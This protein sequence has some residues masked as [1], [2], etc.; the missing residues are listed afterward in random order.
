MQAVLHMVIYQA[1]CMSNGCTQA[2]VGIALP[3]LSNKYWLMSIDSREVAKDANNA[4]L[5]KGNTKDILQ[6][7]SPQY[8]GLALIH[9]PGLQPASE[10]R[11]LP[12]ASLPVHGT[13]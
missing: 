10:A 8:C 6:E 7:L 12:S 9:W 3:M 2:H 13:G 4:S 1:N 11:Y 5:V